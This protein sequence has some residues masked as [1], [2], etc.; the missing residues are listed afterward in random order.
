MRSDSIL[1]VT[2]TPQKRKQ[3][4]PKIIGSSSS[5][6]IP[7]VPSNLGNI[8]LKKGS[9]NFVTSNNT[10]NNTSAI[11]NL[12]PKKG[13][14]KIAKSNIKPVD[15]YI[16]NGA[17]ISSSKGFSSTNTSFLNNGGDNSTHSTDKKGII[18]WSKIKKVA[19]DPN[20]NTNQSH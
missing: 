6:G 14:I 8:P 15:C 3:S 1:K 5:I 20:I 18:S 17:Q 2:G 16:D 13:P 11:K 9:I 7:T 19:G 10:D 12:L 4:L